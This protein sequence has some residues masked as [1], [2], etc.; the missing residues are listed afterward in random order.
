MNYRAAFAILFSIVIVAAATAA[1]ALWSDSLRINT[2]VK[3][4]DLKFC[5][6]NNTLIWTDNG[7]DMNSFPPDFNPEPAPEGKDVGSFEG[8]MI[9]TDGDGCADTLQ[10]TLHNVYPWYYNH[11]G[12]KAVN[13]GTIP[14]KIW[15]M[16]LQ[17][18][19]YYEINE[20]TLFEGV[21]LDLDGDGHNDTLVWWGDN[22]G[23]QLHPG[24]KADISLDITILQEAP[25]NSTLIF[26]IT[27][28]AVQ[29]NEYASGPIG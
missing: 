1:Y 9:D 3:T 5:F 26:N 27:L 6:Q 15:Q 22:F 18:V 29:W 12:F 24:E 13:K 4:G 10:I 16:T 11:I 23:K 21:Y 7:P 17:G 8:V 28:T 25:Q 20:N 14:L 19:K 2:T